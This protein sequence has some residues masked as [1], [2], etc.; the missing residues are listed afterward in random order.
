MEADWAA[1]VVETGGRVLVL[2]PLAVAEQWVR[3]AVNVGI[4]ARYLREDDGCS[5]VIVTNYDI[6]DHFD[7]SRFAGLI[8]DESSILK[9][10]DGATRAAIIASS[11]VVPYRLAATAT[12]S[13]NDYAELGNHAEFLGVCSRAEMLAEFFVHDG[14]DT[15]VWRLKG[16]AVKPFWGF[17]CSWAAIVR[18]PSDLGYDD[19]LYR[20]PPLRWH[21][22]VVDVDHSAYHDAGLLFAPN[23]MGLS[24]QRATRRATRD[25][26]IEEAVKIAA[27]SESVLIWGELNAETESCHLAIPG[28]MEVCGSDS[29]EEKAAALLGFADGKFRVLV[30]KPKIAGFGLNWQHCN[31]I[32]FLG[33]S[34]SYEQTYQA[35][36]RCWRFGQKRPVDVH[37]IRAANEGSVVQNYR[38]KERDAEG[39]W[40]ATRPM[41]AE[42]IRSIGSTQRQITTY[43]PTIPMEIPLWL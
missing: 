30:T 40:N 8:L 29:P 43:N 18:M 1:A 14:G 13:P 3:E 6:L 26:R 16:H 25:A 23:A 31:R 22:H 36:R 20:L 41:V 38:R 7:L 9:A 34:H 2:T 11:Q 35:I 32:V 33:A 28:S 10:Q 42:M 39:M 5:P 12:P 21:E 15:S 17:V 4:Q 37:V 19:T 24:E 27:G